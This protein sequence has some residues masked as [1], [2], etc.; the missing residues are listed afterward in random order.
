MNETPNTPN[1]DTIDPVK[2]VVQEGENKGA[3]ADIELARQGAIGENNERGMLEQNGVEDKSSADNLGEQ[4][5][6]TEI[7]NRALGIIE[8]LNVDTS[9]NSEQKDAFVK[10]AQDG[11]TDEQRSKYNERVADSATK[12]DDVASKLNDLNG[13]R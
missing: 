10:I 7:G 2:L 6:K 3:I 8:G 5:M 4:R 11:F 13:F 1:L 9:N 12:I